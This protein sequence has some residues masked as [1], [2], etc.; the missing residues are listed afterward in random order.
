ME[1]TDSRR[2]K[3]QE[4]SETTETQKQKKAKEKTLG[5]IATGSKD[6]NKIEEKPTKAMV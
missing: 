6:T 3:V 5:R 4:L 2:T 1:C